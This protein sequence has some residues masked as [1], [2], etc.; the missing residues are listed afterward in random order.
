MLC[1]AITRQ[2]GGRVVPFALHVRNDNRECAPPLVLLKA[3][4]GPGDQGEPVVT[5]MLT[6][7]D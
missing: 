6:D 2:G 1:C 5:I 4:Y 7:E 3:V